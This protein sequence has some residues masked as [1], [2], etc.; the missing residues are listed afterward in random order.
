MLNKKLIKKIPTIE[1]IAVDFPIFGKIYNKYINML[2]DSKV[3]IVN[4]QIILHNGN[5]MN[6]E[7]LYSH[8]NKLY[9]LYL[10]Y[11]AL[12]LR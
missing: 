12:Y 5:R 8:D 2:K 1:Q 11:V 7:D 10:S 9:R 4:E 3:D 6:A